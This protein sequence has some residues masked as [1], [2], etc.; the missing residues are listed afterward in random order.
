MVAGVVAAASVAGLFRLDV[1]NSFI[2]YF[3]ESTE[4]HRALA[5]IDRE[6]GG[7]T[8]LDLVYRIPAAPEKQDLVLSA[9]TVLALQRM[10]KALQQHKAVGKVLSVVNF[11]QVA[12]E[13]NHDRPLTEYELTAI[14]WLLDRS[15]RENL[16]GS[17]LSPEHAQARISARIRDTTPGLDRGQLLADIRADMAKLDVPR[18][19]YR[20]TNLFVLYQDL[21]QRLF[22]SQILT[23]G[24]V[25]A[26]LA[27]A[28][29]GIFRSW[30]I[31]LVALAPNMLATL[32]VLGLMGW[33][34]IPLDF[35]TITIASIAMGIA[36]D[37][38]IHYIHR[39]R[40]ELRDGGT[41]RAVTRSHASV[42]YAVLY[43]SVI[44]VL[45][46]SLLAFSDFVPSILFGL[47]TALAMSLALVFALT[48]LPAL[49]S[50]F[51]RST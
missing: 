2:N 10:Q 21:L 6:F 48:V 5:F 38:T 29:L 35:M 4:V 44:I 19:D 32:A 51:V 26:V 16:V 1:E 24:I 30:K 39:Y 8:P 41:D 17:F 37:D 34:R 12:K 18:E 3:R 31:A 33:L 7:T 14:Y 47:L 15:V 25:Y 40:E 20:L 28:F 42:G 46:F 11:T 23:L 36:V 43:T 22:R 50:R 49:L 13:L 45:G 9:E 27:V